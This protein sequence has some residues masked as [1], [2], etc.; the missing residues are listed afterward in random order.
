M[1]ALAGKQKDIQEKEL[2][3]LD[4]QLMLQK[5]NF[6]PKFQ[7]KSQLSKTGNDTTTKAD[8]LATTLSA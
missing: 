4:K 7:I 1:F 2:E 5:I 8:S 6:E 3:Y